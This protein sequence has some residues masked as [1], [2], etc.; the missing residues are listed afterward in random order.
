MPLFLA[1]AASLLLHGLAL[2][3]PGWHLPGEE[4]PPSTLLVAQLQPPPNNSTHR[5]APPSKPKPH[6]PHS[7][8]PPS[9]ALT[10]PVLT[11]ADAASQ[12]TPTL[13]AAPPQEAKTQTAPDAPA[14]PPWV[15]QGSLNYHITYGNGGFVVGVM[16]QNLD[17]A[18]GKYHI[19]SSIKPWS[20]ATAFAKSRHQVSS[21]ELSAQGLQ[22]EK[23]TD[24]IEGRAVDEVGFD[25]SLG[26]AQLAN[27]RG[28]VE[29]TVGMQDPVSVFYQLAWRARASGRGIDQEFRVVTAN[30]AGDWRF[31]WVGEEQIEQPPDKLDT[32]HYRTQSDGEITEIW[33]APALGALPVKIHHIDRDGRVFEMLA[34]KPQTGQPLPDFLNQSQN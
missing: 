29:L 7:V 1:L 23:F 21:G 27:G 20:I 5:K 12:P 2:T 8:K 10:A 16:V 15:A 34:V 22:P 18:D 33:L 31:V 28:K 19:D 3:L 25:W 30:R 24:Q 32:W 14:T 13:P 26:Q 6:P 4:A 9:A 17:F 11:Q